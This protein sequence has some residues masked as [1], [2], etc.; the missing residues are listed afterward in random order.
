MF[1]GLKYEE[2]KNNIISDD[3]SEEI[4]N[5]SKLINYFNTRKHKA[6]NL[7]Q[8]IYIIQI[9]DKLID[10]CGIGYKLNN[11]NIGFIFNDS[12]QMTKITSLS[13]VDIFR[14]SFII[15]YKS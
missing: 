4:L 6:L 11:K 15:I 1:N 13:S 5:D 10:N 14:Y 3:E 8:V 9:Y 7:N 12:S 2:N